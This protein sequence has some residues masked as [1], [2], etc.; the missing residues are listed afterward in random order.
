M[1]EL[2][3]Q[4]LSGLQSEFKAKL[5]NL[6]RI[7]LKNMKCSE[8]WSNN[9]VVEHLNCIPRALNSISQ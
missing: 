1:E 7:Y 6:V 9:S 4:G 3:V 8:S 2:Q 5:D